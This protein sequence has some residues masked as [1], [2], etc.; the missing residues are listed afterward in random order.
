MNTNGHELR[1]SIRVHLRRF[2][3]VQFLRQLADHFED[4]NDDEDDFCFD[5]SSPN[6]AAAPLRV[7]QVHSLR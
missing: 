1:R 7:P 5:Q 6:V 2:V 3:V 4:E